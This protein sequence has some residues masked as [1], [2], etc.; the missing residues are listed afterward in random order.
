MARERSDYHHGDLPAAALDAVD[1]IVREEGP[2]AVSI[3]E[4]AR[5]IG[6]S[7]AAPGH[8]FGDKAGLLTA[9]ATRGFERLTDRLVAAAGGE[10][11]L[12]DA[13]L[14]YVAFALDE[15]G[16][17][18]VMFRPELLH[19]TDP[20][21]QRAE[22]AAFGELLEAVRSVRGA[23]DP[24]DSGLR[25]AAAGAWSIVHGFAALWLQGAL[26][27]DITEGPPAAAA[28]RALAEF[29]ATVAGT[30]PADG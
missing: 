13:G 14:A 7:N 4:V 1:G 28:H 20:A 16:L 10:D 22:T 6:V 15:P 24:D 21:L 23:A 2:G 26:G 27:P 11:R 19:A 5:R 3:R 8:H 17:F 30:D 18:A 9:Y 29:A 12:L 25:F